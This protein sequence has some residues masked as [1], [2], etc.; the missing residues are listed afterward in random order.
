MAEVWKVCVFV[1]IAAFS[2]Y[3]VNQ[4]ALKTILDDDDVTI[5]KKLKRKEREEAPYRRNNRPNY[6]RPTT[7]LQ[8]IEVQPMQ[9]D[10]QN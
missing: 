7:E 4:E 1:L 8:P 2:A 3:A 6:G 10:V 5:A 9:L